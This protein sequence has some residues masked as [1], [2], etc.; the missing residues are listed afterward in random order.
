MKY[1]DWLDVWFA[2]YIEPS[3]KTKTCERYS[4]I[5]EKHLKVKLGEYELEELSPIV[6][7]KY[8]TE[9]KGFH[10]LRHTFATRALEC[11]MDVKTLA[12]ILGHKN[13]T[14]TLN[15][16]AHSLM[17]HKQ[18][19]GDRY[20]D[21]RLS[22]A[23]ITEHNRAAY[24]RAKRYVEYAADMRRENIGLYFYGDNSSGK[25]YITACI[26]NELLRKGYRCVYTNFARILSEI[27]S[28]YSGDG[29]GELDIMR[30]LMTCDFA[31][32]DDFGKEFIGREYNRSA[33]KW[34]EEKLF[35]MINVRYNSKRPTVFS[36]NYAMDE[37]AS[38]LSLDKAIIE[39]VNEM[40]TRVIRLEGDDF[41]AKQL[42]CQNDK[43]IK[44]G[45]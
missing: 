32:L 44:Y 31:F 8:I 28:G 27:R 5:I 6:I 33:A 19:M 16:Y 24:A 26:C 17:E 34:A 23:V 2:N 40:S 29:M 21:C 9:L 39:R 11:G 7:Q 22:T 45:I 10:S 30:K 12:E 15:R 25:T 38:K 3:S 36:S 20:K 37:L 18:D 13:A 1:K 42:S 41:R 35:E 14:V 43:A 4:E